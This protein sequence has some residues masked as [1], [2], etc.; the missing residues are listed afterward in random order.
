M[1]GE[2][3]IVQKSRKW[4]LPLN[5]MVGTKIATCQWDLEQRKVSSKA[6]I[7]ECIGVTRVTGEG[8]QLGDIQCT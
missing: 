8:G 2:P 3:D 5:R 6:Q 7:E 1:L 4:L